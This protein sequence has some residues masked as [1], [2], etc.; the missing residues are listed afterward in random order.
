MTKVY[1]GDINPKK[2][3]QLHNKNLGFQIRLRQPNN[4]RHAIETHQSRAAEWEKSP[5]WYNWT[6]LRN[7]IMER[8]RV[9][10]DDTTDLLIDI[11]DLDTGFVIG[12][13]NVADTNWH[14]RS[15]ESSKCRDKFFKNRTDDEDEDES[16]R[17]D[18]LYEYPLVA[19]PNAPDRS[20]YRKK[21]SVKPKTKRKSKK[22]VKKCRCKK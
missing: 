2:Y 13:I 12:I 14:K 19:S 18:M 3:P 20:Y 15:Q 16:Y 21:K 9:Y 17:H 11:I 4:L 22:V 7:S 1:S 10:C 6:K 5:L 8:E